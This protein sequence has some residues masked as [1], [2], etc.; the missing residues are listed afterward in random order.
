M[1]GAWRAISSRLTLQSRNLLLAQITKSSERKSTGPKAYR[2]SRRPPGRR[3]RGRGRFLTV[4]IGG[5]TPGGKVQVAARL[6][7]SQAPI[8]TVASTQRRC[9]SNGYVEL[10]RQRRCERV[11]GN[12]SDGCLAPRLRGNSSVGARLAATLVHDATAGAHADDAVAAF[13]AGVAQRVRPRGIGWAGPSA[14]AQR[15]AAQVGSQLCQDRFAFVVPGC[16]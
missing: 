11:R 4:L 10:H 14:A 9:E 5:T 6:V 3:S 7:R 15:T 12:S 1:A 8:R 16:T 13:D 2:S